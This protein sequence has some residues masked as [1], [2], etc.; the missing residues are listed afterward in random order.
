MGSPFFIIKLLDLLVVTTT[1]TLADCHKNK[2]FGRS[3]QFFFF[4]FF[5][6]ISELFF[7][8]DQA[9]VRP[10]FHYISLIVHKRRSKKRK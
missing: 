3:S 5:Y 2:T 8:F 7:I 6:H 1:I 10:F 9:S 4:F